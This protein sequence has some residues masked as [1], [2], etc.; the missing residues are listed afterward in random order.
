MTERISSGDIIKNFKDAELTMSIY[1]KLRADEIVEI[2]ISQYRKIFLKTLAKMQIFSLTMNVL[3]LIGG[4]GA[5]AY[6]GNS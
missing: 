2:N 1:E 6:T 3:R 4:Y 5:L